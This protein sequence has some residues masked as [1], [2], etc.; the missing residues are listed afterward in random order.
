[1]GEDQGLIHVE[2]IDHVPVRGRR[3]QL[4]GAGAVPLDA[5]VDHRALRCIAADLRQGLLHQAVPGAGVLRLRHLVEKLQRHMAPAPVAAGQPAPQGQE[6]LP[7]SR[8]GEEI[9]FRGVA[10]VIEVIARRLVQVQDQVQPRLLTPVHQRVH[11][12]HALGKLAA[13]LPLQHLIVDGDAH[14]VKAPVRQLPDILL[15]QKAAVVFQRVALALA[16]PAAQIDAPFELHR[17]PSIFFFALS[18][19]AMSYSQPLSSSQ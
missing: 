13:V 16:E 5:A 11:Q 1:M 9:V 17:F 8:R 3:Q 2:G 7:Q 10:C 4:E 15:P 12:G 19:R 14:M 6:A 18:N